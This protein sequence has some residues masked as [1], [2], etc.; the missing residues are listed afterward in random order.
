MVSRNEKS[1]CLSID[2]ILKELE[3]GNDVSDS[4][5]LKEKATVY[6]GCEQCQMALLNKL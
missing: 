6:Y 5:T 2:S 1:L 3:L 4:G